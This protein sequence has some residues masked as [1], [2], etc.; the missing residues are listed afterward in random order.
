MVSLREL[1]STFAAAMRDSAVACA[2]VPQTNLA[3]YR[4][5]SAHTFRIALERT[6]P[7]ILKRVGA[8]YFGQ[9]AV[10]YRERFPSRSGDLHWAGCDFAAFLD[11]HLRDGEYAWLAD[12]ARVEWSHE[13]ASVAA[14]APAIGAESLARFE[15]EQL[16]RLLFTLQPS[17]R[18]HSSSYPVFSVWLNN[19]AATAPPVDQSLGSECGL[20]RARY[21]DAEVRVLEPRFFSYLSALAAG[22]SLGDAMTIAGL[23]EQGLVSSLGFLFSENLVSA[24]SLKGDTSAL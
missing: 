2:V 7:V 14:E 24:V 9:L 22:A 15:P 21:D 10:R 23:D 18:L 6:F 4:N 1:Q 17:L 13:E 16:E 3:I 20:V 12:L 11:D 8:D 19:Q 5:N